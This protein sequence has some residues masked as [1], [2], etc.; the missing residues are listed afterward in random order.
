MPEAVLHPAVAAS[1][2]RIYVFGG[3]DAMQNPV[4]IIQVNSFDQCRRSHLSSFI[5]FTLAS[6]L[7]PA[8]VSHREEHVVQDGEQDGE[9]RV[10]SSCRYRRQDLY[11]RRCVRIR[12]KLARAPVAVRLIHANRATSRPFSCHRIHP[13]GHRVRHQGQPLRQVCQPEGEEDAPLCHRP[14]KQTLH[15]RRTFHCQRRRRGGLGQ[16]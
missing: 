16:F 4:R 2:Q 7:P 1:N 3:E 15:H 9:E 12:T 8:G 5:S 10:G 13:Q 6:C 11:H 14:Q